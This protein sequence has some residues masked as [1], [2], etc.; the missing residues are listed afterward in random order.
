MRIELR[1]HLEKSPSGMVEDDFQ[2]YIDTFLLDGASDAL[3][4]VLVLPGGGYHHRAKHEGDPVAE[5]FNALGYHAFVLQYR[6]TPYTFPAPQR[7]LVRAVKIIQA[8]AQQWKL[9]KLAVLG[10]SA[11][12]HLA[13]SGTV[14]HDQINAD[15]GDEADKFSGKADAMIL[16]YPVIS[17]SDDFGHYGSGEYLFGKGC[18]TGDM[19]AMDVHKAVTPGVPPAFLW[20]TA[21]D[22]T[23]NVQNS[24]IFARQMWQNENKCELHVFPE[25]PH[26][27]GLAMGRKDISV[28]PELAAQFLE[29]TAG[30]LRA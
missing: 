17:L 15:E 9:G 20:H 21:T 18:T 26:G 24:M 22:A 29:T 16:C 11:G 7:D 19:A 2:P 5:K 23:V 13:A 4:G 25:A 30:F 8:N 28:W 3:G 6:V 27:K 1:N 12:G 14:F 10:F